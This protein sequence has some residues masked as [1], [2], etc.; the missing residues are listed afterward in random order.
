MQFLVLVP[1]TVPLWL[2]PGVRHVD[3]AVS[4]LAVA[5]SS[6]EEASGAARSL[7]DLQDIETNSSSSTDQ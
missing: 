7:Q 6:G 1:A 4:D 5:T 2:S 3:D